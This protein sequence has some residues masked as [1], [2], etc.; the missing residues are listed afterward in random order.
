VRKPCTA[1]VTSFVVIHHILNKKLVADFGLTINEYH[2]LVLMKCCNNSLNGKK[3]AYELNLKPSSVS[4]IFERLMHMGAIAPDSRLGSGRELYYG[5]TRD[6]LV[7]L[8]RAENIIQKVITRIWQ[9][10]SNERL[11]SIV[12]YCA[13]AVLQQQVKS[14]SGDVAYTLALC[15]TLDS[16]NQITKTNNISL[17]EYRILLLLDERD[18]YLSPAA[19]ARELFMHPNDVSNRCGN[20]YEKGFID[21]IRK[22]ENRRS[23]FLKLT[24]SGKQLER[25]ISAQYQIVFQQKPGASEAE[26]HFRCA[27]K[28]VERLKRNGDIANNLRYI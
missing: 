1:W 12:R 18:E 11:E 23:V 24:D 25:I 3:L 27:E 16:I 17:S 10:L 20:L 2:T 19:V 7:L 15:G 5:I 21:R 13:L 28:I 9:P 22:P 6:G 4:R 14:I 8:K 26:A